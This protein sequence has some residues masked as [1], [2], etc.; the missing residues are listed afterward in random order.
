M[1]LAASSRFTRSRRR[2]GNLPYT[3]CC[4]AQFEALATSRTALWMSE[5][6]LPLHVA[7]SAARDKYRRD[8]KGDARYRDDAAPLNLACQ[9]KLDL[10]AWPRRR[11]CFR[12]TMPSSSACRFRPRSIS[13][14]RG[15]ERFVFRI[16]GRSHRCTRLWIEAFLHG[17]LCDRLWPCGRDQLAR[18]TRPG[19]S[20]CTSQSLEATHPLSLW[21]STWS[22]GWIRRA[23]RTPEGGRPQR[24]T[25]FGTI[26][27]QTEVRVGPRN[28]K[29]RVLAHS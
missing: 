10:V 23:K 8:G 26:P 15:P 3:W 27:G 28:D 11:A 18:R 29:R 1:W 6:S 22:S 5:G 25:T 4:I 7:A 2:S 16:R 17:T 24:E 19:R 20:P 14:R 13:S 9:M 21:C 12:C